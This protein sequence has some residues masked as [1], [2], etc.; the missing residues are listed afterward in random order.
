MAGAGDVTWLPMTSSAATNNSNWTTTSDGRDDA[1]FVMVLNRIVVPVLFGLITV[2]GLSGNGL[3]I[4]VIVTKRRMRTV[5]NLLL[6]NLAIADVCF[7]L[8][9]P[10]F[11]A[12]MQA[13]SSWP[14]GDV[15]C[16]L[17]HYLVNVTAYVIVTSS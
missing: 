16:R 17:L 2:V 1:M 3:V 6:L 11:T 9:I 8:V 14:F 10:P 15:A 4:H 7:V 5:T 13:T 12:Y